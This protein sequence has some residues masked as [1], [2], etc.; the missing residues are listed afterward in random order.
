VAAG[1]LRRERSLLAF[2]LNEVIPWRRSFE[3]YRRIFSLTGKDL[4]GRILGCGDGPASFN[5]GATIRGHAAVSCDPIYAFA[6]AEVGQRVND[7]APLPERIGTSTRSAGQ[8][9]SNRGAESRCRLTSRFP[10]PG[11]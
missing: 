4:A 6:P 1:I 3:E 7:W 5:T 8:P 11:P 10:R 9:A 2:K